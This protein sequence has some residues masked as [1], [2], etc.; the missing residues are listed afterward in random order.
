MEKVKRTYNYNL[1]F[2][3]R[4][5]KLA[6][7]INLSSPDLQVIRKPQAG[8]RRNQLWVLEFFSA[9]KNKLMKFFKLVWVDVEN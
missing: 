3:A 9:A 7:N 8:I 2:G 5:I 1:A 6:Q 4:H